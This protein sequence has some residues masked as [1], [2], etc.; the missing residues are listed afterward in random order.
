MTKNRRT[1]KFDPNPPPPL[2]QIGISFTRFGISIVLTLSGAFFLTSSFV[3]DS[4]FAVSLVS[5]I[6]G[7]LC[8]LP[9][10]FFLF[11]TITSYKRGD[12]YS[13]LQPED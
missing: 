9:G 10:L 2:G 1:P 12:N 13:I 11:E 6:L 3:G 4:Y 7:L 8:L 5:L